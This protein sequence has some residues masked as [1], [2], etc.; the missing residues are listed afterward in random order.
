MMNLHGR[1][2]RRGFARA[3]PENGQW[4]IYVETGS[5]D[6]GSVIDDT[7]PTREAVEHRLNDLIARY[8]RIGY[9]AF[10]SPFEVT[11]PGTPF[12]VKRPN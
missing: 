9:V 3:W 11:T 5:A 1:H 4:R 7:C 6:D 12:L 8:A 10:G 2:G